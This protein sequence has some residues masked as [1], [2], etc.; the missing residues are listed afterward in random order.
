MKSRTISLNQ[1]GTNSYPMFLAACGSVYLG[2]PLRVRLARHVRSTDCLGSIIS[3]GHVDECHVLIESSRGHASAGRFNGT[4]RNVVPS[5]SA[6]LPSRGGFVF[7]GPTA[8]Y[9]RPRHRD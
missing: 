2:Q 3:T 4:A 7:T 1:P 6:R 8:T 9:F 5:M